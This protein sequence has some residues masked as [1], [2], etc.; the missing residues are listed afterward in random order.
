MVVRWLFNGKALENWADLG[1]GPGNYTSAVGIKAK[2]GVGVDMRESAPEL[3]EFFK[4]ERKPIEDWLQSKNEDE[5][6]LVSSFDVVEHFPKEDALVLMKEM[7]RVGRE[8]LISTPGGFLVQDAETHPEHKDNPWQWHRSGFEPEDF[9]RLGFLVFVL[10][11]HHYKPK[12]NDRSFDKLL[13]LWAGGGSHYAALAHFV[14]RR[15]ALYLMR[16]L[17]FFRM[18]RDVVLKPFI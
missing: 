16:P 13:C 11:N 1:C 12:G 9:E 5:F 10:R 17:H 2:S 8:V 14:R 4:F 18:V 6:D 7:R 15:N 3:P